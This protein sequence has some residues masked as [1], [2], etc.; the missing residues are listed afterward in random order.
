MIP[1]FADPRDI[2]LARRF[3]ESDWS[4]SS[5]SPMCLSTDD[6]YNQVS[7]QIYKKPIS[8]ALPEVLC[9]TEALYRGSGHPHLVQDSPK[10]GT[11]N[12]WFSLI[13]SKIKWQW[14][15]VNF[16]QYL[17]PV[18]KIYTFIILKFWYL[19]LVYI[20]AFVAKLRKNVKFMK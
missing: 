11:L 1:R 7:Q 14:N 2:Q 3:G 13:Y 16:T 20:F 4:S 19:L 17:T 6:Y 9:R 15:S 10:S 8:S 18:L 12:V 5:S